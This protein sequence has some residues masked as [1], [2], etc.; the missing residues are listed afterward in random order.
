[1][2]FGLTEE[3][4]LVQLLI[5]RRVPH[6]HILFIPS[7]NGPCIRLPKDAVH[8]L[9]V[10]FRIRGPEFKA[11]QHSVISLSKFLD[12]ISR[13]LVFIVNYLLLSVF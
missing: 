7:D 6:M 13:H 5:G 12:L 2:R 10:M 4:N 11:K 3:V 9:G 1:M 8:L